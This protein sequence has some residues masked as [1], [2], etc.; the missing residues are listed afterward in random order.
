MTIK[1]Q[2]TDLIFFRLVAHPL[3]VLA[4]LL[5]TFFFRDGNDGN[6]FRFASQTCFQSKPYVLDAGMKWV[7]E[8]LPD[9]NYLHVHWNPRVNKF[10]IILLLLLLLLYFSSFLGPRISAKNKNENQ[11]FP[12]GVIYPSY[13]SF[14]I[15]LFS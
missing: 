11:D 13:K 7:E 2:L 9:E 3:H 4:R 8:N 12:R 1:R 15:L 14:L 10:K 5:L 6:V